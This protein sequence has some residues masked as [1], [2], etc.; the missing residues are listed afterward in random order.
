MTPEELAAMEYLVS[1]GLMRV[2]HI[3]DGQYRVWGKT[4]LLDKK[5]LTEEEEQ[6][7]LVLYG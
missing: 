1:V 6:A 3:L 7:M 4:P 2:T 5:T